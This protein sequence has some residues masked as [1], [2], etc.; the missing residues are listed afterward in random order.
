MIAAVPLAVPEVAWIVAEPVPTAV[1][2]PLAE[3]VATAVLLL[4]QVIGAPAMT[5]PPASRAV[6]PNVTVC[7]IVERP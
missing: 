7:P 1:T 6:A 2:T 4:V 5:F 3:T